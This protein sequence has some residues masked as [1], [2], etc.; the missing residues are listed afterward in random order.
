MLLDFFSNI[1]YKSKDDI[2]DAVIDYHARVLRPYKT[3]VSNKRQYKAVCTIASCPLVVRF[4]FTSSFYAPT[5]FVP[6][7]C[8][9]DTTSKGANKKQT[10]KSLAKNEEVRKLFVQCGRNMTPIIIQRRVEKMGQAAMYMNSVNAFARL[11]NEFY[12]DE[13][14]QYTKLMSYVK[15]LNANSHTATCEVNDGTSQ[16]L[17]ILYREGIRTFIQSPSRG[18]SVDGTFSKTFIGGMLLAACFL[19]GNN[20][21]QII[22]VAVVPI[23]NEDNWTFFLKFLTDHLPHQP[24][25]VISDRDKGLV[26]AVKTLSQEL[27]HIFCFRHLMENFNRKFKSKLLKKHCLESCPIIR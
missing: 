22:G 2:I 4:A 26:P 15:C 6:H 11:K 12:G 8:A 23:E 5:L 1:D 3:I 20:E 14:E 7:S 21:L 9:V 27:H 18:M 13:Y 17:A 10:A 16:R 24:S 25:F 19:N